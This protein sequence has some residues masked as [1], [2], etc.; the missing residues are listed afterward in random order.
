MAVYHGPVCRLCRREG[1]KLFLKGERCRTEKCAFERRP[2]APGQRSMK[3]RR[4]MATEY[5]N[6]LREKQ[7]I[8]RIYGVLEKQ[9]RLY[10]DEASRRDGV[11]GENLLKLLELRLDNLVYRLGF[12]PSR[13]SA[14][15]MVRHN[16]FLINGKKVN[17]P[18]YQ[19]K[20]GDTIQVKEKSKNVELIHAALKTV[21]D[22][23]EWLVVDKVKLSGSVV[24]LPE[25]SDVSAD[26][27]EQLVVELYS[28]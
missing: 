7:K 18:S 5:N 8:R 14:R 4:N 22:I 9:F 3:R 28:K 23:P 13:I 2:F 1:G 16:H 21:R 15:Q 19:I 10:F 26:I 11:T 17:I 12:A 24:R 20:A 27:Q 25:R 6:Q